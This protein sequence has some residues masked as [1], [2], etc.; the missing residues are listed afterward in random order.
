MDDIE[1]AQ[2]QIDFA[3]DGKNQFTCDDVVFAVIVCGVESDG[4]AKRRVHELRLAGPVG[5]IGTGIV[6]VPLKLLANHFDMQ[7]GGRRA[8]KA[9]ARPEVFRR[10]RHHDVEDDE[11]AKR[12]ELGAPGG[13]R[14]P[15]AG[16]CDDEVR[17]GRRK[18]Q[19][20]RILAARKQT[21]IAPTSQRIRRSTAKP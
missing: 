8:L 17:R 15:R 19:T 7:G 18:S 4:I 16:V 2:L 1:R 11:Q 6:E 3:V 10:H 13:W 9:L 5:G 20:R 14:P 21:V 12:N